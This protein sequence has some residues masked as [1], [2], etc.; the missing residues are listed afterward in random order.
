MTE[1][2]DTNNL[3]N[4][5][6][7]FIDNVK[8]NVQNELSD[9]FDEQPDE[10]PDERPDEQ[11]DERPDEPLYLEKLGST[12]FDGAIVDTSLEFNQE[13]R[14]SEINHD[15]IIMNLQGS[16]RNRRTRDKCRVR[17]TKRVTKN[18]SNDTTYYTDQIVRIRDSN[19]GNYQ[20]VEFNSPNIQLD[21]TQLRD[22]ANN[23]CNNICNNECNKE[24]DETLDK[25]NVSSRECEE[26]IIMDMIEATIQDIINENIQDKDLEKLVENGEN[27]VKTGENLV[28]K[29]E[30]NE[31]DIPCIDR[32]YIDNNIIF[33]KDLNTETILEG[34]MSASEDKFNHLQEILNTHKEFDGILE[35]TPHDK[36]WIED[37]T[38]TRKRSDGSQETVTIP[39]LTVHQ[40][41]T[42]YVGAAVRTYY[43]M[44]REKILSH[45][46]GIVDSLERQVEYTDILTQSRFVPQYSVKIHQ[47][48]EKLEAQ[49]LNQ[50]ADHQ[51]EI[52][53]FVKRIRAVADKMRAI[54]EGANRGN[55]SD[56]K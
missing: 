44:G 7:T 13:E 42:G 47:V 41:A 37:V 53:D 39:R 17:K 10:Q 40:G 48:A 34:I 3:E 4:R 25:N 5:V 33:S 45:V 32:T 28:E 15:D 36:L 52:E 1:K 55:S 19:I 16:G 14:N 43:G 20:D 11:P 50:Y 23:N 9:I 31:K 24:C 8:Y 54:H 51:T 26:N 46:K 21:T 38:E 29:P 6:K 2:V 49:L 30:K 18:K 27:L 12:K 35:L 56:A 22:I